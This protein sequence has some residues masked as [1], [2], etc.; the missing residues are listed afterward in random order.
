MCA[1][2]D[3]DVA[4]LHVYTIP[5]NFE[6]YKPIQRFQ[7]YGFHKV[8][9]KCHLIG[10]V[11][12]SRANPYWAN[13]QITMTLH[14]YRFRQVCE[15]LNGVNPSSGFREMLSTK[16]GAKFNKLFGPWASPY[17]A[18]GRMTITVQNYKPWQFH[19]TSNG[20]NPSS[21]WRDMGPAHTP[22]HPDHDD[23]QEGWVVMK[24]L[25]RINKSHNLSQQKS[26]LIK[27]NLR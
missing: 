27:C 22:A 15:T 16:S 9:P 23:S 2:S 8:R 11:F 19:K 5:K 4:Q 13:G 10:Q 21:S 3:H 14:N 12:G 6:W 7:R 1:P 26:T 25:I 18:N 20:E 24:S 17:V